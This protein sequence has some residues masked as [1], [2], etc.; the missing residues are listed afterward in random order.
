VFWVGTLRTELPS[1]SSYLLGPTQPANT[2][3]C[4]TLRNSVVSPPRSIFVLCCV[5]R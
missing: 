4:G 1:S 2:N 5:S 3:T